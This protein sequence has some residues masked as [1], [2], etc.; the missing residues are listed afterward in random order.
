M[1]LNAR[2]PTGKHSDVGLHTLAH[3]CMRTRARTVSVGVGAGKKGVER[4]QF[5]KDG[6]VTQLRA[7]A[8]H[9]TAASTQQ[10][11]HTEQRKPLAAVSTGAT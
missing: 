10:R 5:K 4:L 8:T 7:Q 11:K 3:T 9:R 2:S 1:G 6:H